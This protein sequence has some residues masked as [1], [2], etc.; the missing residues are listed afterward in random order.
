MKVL[1]IGDVVGRAGRRVLTEHFHRVVDR[2]GIDF[3]ICNVENAADGRG[4]TPEIARQILDLGVDCM[5][6]GN[7][8]W[9]RKE[10]AD[11]ID[12]EPRLLRPLNYPEE[13]PGSGEWV[14]STPAGIKVA[15][16]NAMGRVF[17]PPSEDPFRMLPERIHHLREQTPI[18]VVDF[19]AEASSEKIA[20][21]WHLDGKASAVLGTHTHVQTADDRVLPH[22]TAYIT[23]VGM[24]GPFDSVIGMEKKGALARFLDNRPRRLSSAKGDA[25]LCGVV[26]EIDP[27]TGRA[28]SIERLMI[29]RDAD[30]SARHA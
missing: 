14:G 20:M 21:G 4:V 11:Y 8:I 30:G 23:D 17:M 19:H 13:T 16:V 3:S 29:P 1:F 28:R 22:G 24:T 15:V 2:H 6:S 12:S 18:V 5:T 9:D 26:L 10:V 25:R 7:H 27:E